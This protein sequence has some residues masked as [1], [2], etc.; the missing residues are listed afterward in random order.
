M[1]LFLPA[2]LLVCMIGCSRDP[3][4]SASVTGKVNYKGQPVTGGTMTLYV[5]EAGYPTGLSPDGA[6][7]L[8]QIP[9]G[10]GTITVN[11]DAL[12]PNK[13]K[14]GG[15]A[16]GMSPMPEYAAEKAKGAYVKIPAKYKNKATS[17]LKVSLKAGKQ[18]KDFDLTD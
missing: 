18:Q 14:Y 11:T 7:S 15:K 12:N 9:E 10:E 16:G 6:Y 8:T 2:L 4:R 3:S 17:D 5:G 1:R 13:P